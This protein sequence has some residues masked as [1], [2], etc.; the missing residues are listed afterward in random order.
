ML[1]GFAGENAIE[2]LCQQSLCQSQPNSKKC[3]K[4][5]VTPLA[6]ALLKRAPLGPHRKA[7]GPD[8]KEIS[9]LSH[10]QCAYFKEKGHWKSE[11]PSH[12][13]K[14]TKAAG[15]LSQY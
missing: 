4:Q 3:M 5:K 10:D 1:E 7:R 12:P 2:L 6:A 8:L 11:C 13:E 15:P 14:K 9:P